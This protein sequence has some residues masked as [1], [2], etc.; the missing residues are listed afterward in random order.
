MRKAITRV[1]LLAGWLIMLC[2][3]AAHAGVLTLGRTI[4]KSN[5]WAWIW[6]GLSA[7]FELLEKH[8]TVTKGILGASV[9]AQLLSIFRSRTSGFS[10][11]LFLLILVLLAAIALVVLLKR[12]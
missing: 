12:K 6:A 9:A 8:P 10:W 2:A 11:T 5:P 3:H 4:L 7:L 1:I